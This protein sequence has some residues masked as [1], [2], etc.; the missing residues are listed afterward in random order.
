MPAKHGGRSLV[1]LRTLWP[2]VFKHL[3][4]CR[5]VTEPLTFGAW[6]RGSGEQRVSK[7][8]LRFTPDY[9]GSG[10][11]RCWVPGKPKM[12]ET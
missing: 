9:G 1:R 6:S 3:R 7:A 5:H 8:G 12:L 10:R 11:G 2:S 4:F